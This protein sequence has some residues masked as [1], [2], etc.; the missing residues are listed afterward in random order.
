MSTQ[1]PDKISAPKSD[2]K[3]IKWSW[4]TLSCVSLLTGALYLTTAELTGP[5]AISQVQ[6][7]QAE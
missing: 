2:P 1:T 6:P 5:T 3:S 4:L 7:Q